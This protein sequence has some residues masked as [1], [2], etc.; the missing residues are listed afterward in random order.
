M[1]TTLRVKRKGDYHDHPSTCIDEHPL[2]SFR[3]SRLRHRDP[4]HDVRFA[5]HGLPL[6]WLGP[7]PR[8]RR[9]RFPPPALRAGHHSPTLAT[10][11]CQRARRTNAIPRTTRFPAPLAPARTC[12]AIVA[13]SDSVC[14][15]EAPRDRLSSSAAFAAGFPVVGLLNRP[16]AG[17]QLGPRRGGDA[18]SSFSRAPP[19]SPADSDCA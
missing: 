18:T 8:Q 9:F 14:E 4:V 19:T 15:T 3:I 13:A 7:R 11:C 12:L 16:E 2:G 1:T 17:R 5:S 6:A 10:S